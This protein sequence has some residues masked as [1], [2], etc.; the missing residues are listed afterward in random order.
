MNAI[1]L[2]YSKLRPKNA[3]GIVASIPRSVI[4]DSASER[5][6]TPINVVVFQENKIHLALPTC[7]HT[8]SIRL[9]PVLN[10]IAV[11]SSIH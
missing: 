1:F 10:R 2:I 3:A 11:D 9:C 5:T 6:D 7:S 4:S 8:V